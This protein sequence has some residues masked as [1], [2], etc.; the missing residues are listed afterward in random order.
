[1]TVQRRPHLSQLEPATCSL[2]VTAD[3]A[4]LNHSSE[5]VTMKLN[6][7]FNFHGNTMP[8]NCVYRFCCLDHYVYMKTEH[9]YD[10]TCMR[11]IQVYLGQD[12]I[13]YVI[14]F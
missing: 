5:L 4:R 10:S 9:A 1:M 11:H 6:A 13:F 14:F 12:V 2:Q 8:T 3:G 7:P